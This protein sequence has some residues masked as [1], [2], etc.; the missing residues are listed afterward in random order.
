MIA[1]EFDLHTVSE[2][3]T[4]EHHFARA[5]RTKLQKEVTAANLA[6]KGL[7]PEAIADSRPT[8]TLVRLAPS[9]QV[10]DDDNLRGSLKHVRDQVAKWLGVDDSPRGPVT[11]GY[12][13][14]RRTGPQKKLGGVRIEIQRGAS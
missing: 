4:A 8:I 13:Q 9:A 5:K 7:D 2:A 3:N 6:S 12:R 10:L 11:W 1:V 14:E